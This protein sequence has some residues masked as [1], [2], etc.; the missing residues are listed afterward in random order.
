MD[1]KQ[2][3]LAIN[4]A[5]LWGLFMILAN[6]TCLLLL[7]TQKGRVPLNPGVTI[8]WNPVY[9]LANM[10]LVAALVYGLF[11]RSLLCAVLLIVNG[12][13]RTTY[14]L[15]VTGRLVGLTLLVSIVL[16][17]WAIQGILTLRQPCQDEVRGI[18]S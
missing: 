14:I 3:T 15:L 13:G 1:K 5:C 18:G 2:A 4:V 11:R 12:L 10:L 9:Q 6:L 7:L 8:P 17:A 16:I